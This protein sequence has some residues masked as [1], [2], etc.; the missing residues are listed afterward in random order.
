MQ[1]IL[2]SS[3][4]NHSDKYE[5]IQGVIDYLNDLRSGL[6]NNEEL[7]REFP[8]AQ[9][10]YNCDL[11]CCEI[12]SGGLDQFFTNTGFD[13]D[14]NNFILNGLK[15]M[16]AFKN[17]ALFSK[18]LKMVEQTEDDSIHDKL[19]ELT[20]IFYDLEDSESIADLNYAYI[21]SIDGLKVVSDD[22]YQAEL[23]TILST[24]SDYEERKTIA[25][26][27]WAKNKPRYVKV[28]EALCHKYALELISLNMIDH[29]H[30]IV[31]DEQAD[32]NEEM[33]VMFYYFSTDQGNHY[34]I[35]SGELA[36]L[37]QSEDHH[38]L[39]TITND[40]LLSKLG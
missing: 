24:I 4:F 28:T 32:K 25:D 39:G 12:D 19:D 5:R 27:L 40:E 13:P 35:D 30:D 34:I 21:E 29:G 26:E 33:G 38:V 15:H 23:T 14:I 31:S 6:F 10:I 1:T 22:D 20:E 17:H 3:Q 11:Y 7:D 9:E 16:K 36:T 8:Q 18:A 2:K 37:I